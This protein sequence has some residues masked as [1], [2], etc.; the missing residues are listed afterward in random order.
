MPFISNPEQRRGGA[1]GSHTANKKRS[2]KN[3]GPTAN[4]NL[5]ATGSATPETVTRRIAEAAQL[6][7]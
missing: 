4:G 6:I 2:L 5:V 1:G 3:T 7:S